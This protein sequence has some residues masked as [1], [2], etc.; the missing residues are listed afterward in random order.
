MQWEEVTAIAT[1]LTAIGAFG[2]IMIP[3][4]LSRPRVFFSPPKPKGGWYFITEGGETLK[5]VKIIISL[6][7][8][9]RGQNGTTIKGIFETEVDKEPTLFYSTDTIKIDGQ[10]SE[11]QEKAI[12]LIHYKS[13][14]IREGYIFH[15]KLK[16]K[17][18]G[19][20]MLLFFGK[21]Y[22]SIDLD[23]P[24]NPEKMYDV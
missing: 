16:L 8:E 7:L 15:G 24:Y 3:C 5:G 22:I 4:I 2:A 12:K 18:W 20:R 14:P 9:N 11:V 6:S 1:S 21:K 13:L 17:P 19:N 23:I 10:G